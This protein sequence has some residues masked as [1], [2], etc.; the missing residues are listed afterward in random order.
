MTQR[1]PKIN[2]KFNIQLWTLFTMLGLLISFTSCDKG[3]DD[4]VEED[5]EITY[6]TLK[7][8]NQHGMKHLAITS[9]S[10]IGNPKALFSIKVCQLDIMI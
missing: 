1:K 6:P 8:V 3:N 5:T 9:V 7:I 10:L 2:M 4:V